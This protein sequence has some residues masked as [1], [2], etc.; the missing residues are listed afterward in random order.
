MKP[1]SLPEPG[2]RNASNAIGKVCAIFR[3]LSSAAPLRLNEISERTGFNRVTTLRI[4][5]ELV[6]HRFLARAG[7]P[8]RYSLGPEAVAMAAASSVTQ[9]VR[10][11]ARPSLVRLASSS[12][13]T[14]LLSVRSG[15]ESICV[16]RIVGT[17]PIQA[18]YLQIGSRRW[19]GVGAGSMALLAWLP[20]T[21]RESV[22]DVVSQRLQ[23]YPRIDRSV[24]SQHIESAVDRGYVKMLDIV[25]DRI[26]GIGYP[27]RNREGEV[28][29][30]IS[31]AAL[32][33]RIVEREAELAA[34]LRREANAIQAIV[35]A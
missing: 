16:D 24:L 28:I 20:T 30:A 21:E 11:T 32:T 25:V 17:F 19:L 7:S 35:N 4:L 34:I 15:V 29:A 9:D 23:S 22:L 27:I 26:G 3:T 10:T 2:D 5:D 14:V 18:T 13:D 33:E 6:A 1:A 8:P 31:V 12:E